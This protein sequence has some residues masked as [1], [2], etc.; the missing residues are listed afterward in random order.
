MAVRTQVKLYLTA[1]SS[2]VR[3]LRTGDAGEIAF[4]CACLDDPNSVLVSTISGVVLKWRWTDGTVLQK[5]TLQQCPLYIAEVPSRSDQETRALLLLGDTNSPHRQLVLA[6]L[7]SASGEVSDSELLL[8]RDNLTSA[9]KILDQAKYLV[10]SAGNNIIIGESFHDKKANRSGYRWREIETP[11][12]I[13]S[14]EAKCRPSLTKKGPAAIDVA[15][16]G[17]KGAILVYHDLLAKMIRS[18]KGDEADITGQRLVW[19]R[20]EVLALKWSLDGNYLISGSHE[21][22]MVIWQLD[23][24]E[25]QYLPHLSASITNITVAPSGSV[26][27]VQLANNSIM[28]LSTSELQPIAHI[29][30]LAVQQPN[31]IARDVQP[32]PAVLHPSDKSTIVLAAPTETQSRNRPSLTLLQ[33]YDVVTSVQR[34]KQALTRN[35]ITEISV[36]PEGRPVREPD[37]RHMRISSD[38]KWL[39]TIDEWM[40]LE[41]EMRLACP[42]PDSDNHFQIESYLKFWAYQET[43]KTWQL[44]TKIQGSPSKPPPHHD[45]LD[46]SSH[47]HRAEFATLSSEHVVR[48]W[49]PE[50]HPRNAVAFQKSAGE[51][52]ASWVCKVAVPIQEVSSLASLPPKTLLGSL[53]YSVDGSSLACAS[54][55]SPMVTFINPWDGQ[56]V[57]TQRGSKPGQR[58]HLTFLNHHL[59]T[60]GGDLRVYNAV[61]RDLLYA[62]SLKKR[63]SHV[64]IAANE[65]DSTFAMVFRVPS[66]GP[67]GKLVSKSYIMVSTTTHSWPQSLKVV[68]GAVEVLAALPGESGYLLINDEAETMYLRNT[69]QGPAGAVQSVEGLSQARE[70]MRHGLEDLFGQSTITDVHQGPNAVEDAAEDK[71][72]QIEASGNGSSLRRVFDSTTTLSVPELFRRVAEVHL[73]GV[74]REVRE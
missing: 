40:P 25:H 73:R 19:H 50:G 48:I 36:D 49:T 15:I 8:E 21:T 42:E 54:N 43:S 5:W 64:L 32:T 44:V 35:N 6:S 55:A 45:L 56:V 53:A 69:K 31:P 63:A 41:E 10:L 9:V 24:R 27:A 68:P 62:W 13:V 65:T 39:A 60:I 51:S 16:S 37:V 29:S 17:S 20:R 74:G 34:A 59:I 12:T 4:Y 2:L 26:Y 30:G 1:T 72:L 67:S 47:P 22:V 38:G 57:D 23:T 70:E 14:L 46:L 3:A 18:E 71:Q 52:P 61:S 28:V 33:T 66:Q 58:S 7:D 11:D